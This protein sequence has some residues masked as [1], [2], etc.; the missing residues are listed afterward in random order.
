MA[1]P[2][3]KP[4]LQPYDVTAPS[5]EDLE[6][7]RELIQQ[8]ASLPFGPDRRRLQINLTARIFRLRHPNA[9]GNKEE[10]DKEIDAKW[11]RDHKEQTDKAKK[12]WLARNPHKRKEVALDWYYRNRPPLKERTLVMT[13]IAV[14][15]RNRRL[16]DLQFSLAGRLRATMNRAFRRKWVKKPVRTEELFGCSISELKAHI[17]KQF[18]NGMS[19]ENRKAFHIDHIVPVI[20]FN[21]EDIEEVKCAFNWKNL[22]PLF[23]RDNLR[24]QATIPNPLPS[25]LPPHIAERI[26]LR[27]TQPKR[28]HS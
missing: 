9:R 19:W 5:A 26:T 22:R 12:A 23:G 2:G 7:I 14:Y 1:G 24:K 17:E 11:H 4:K 20:A 13:P 6:K 15:T 18:I 10:H 8:R 16:N 3:P 27:S 28:P 25:W 21:M